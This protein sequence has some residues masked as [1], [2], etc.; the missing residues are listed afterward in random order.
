MIYVTHDQ[1][2]AMTMA[3]RIVVLNRG[4]IEQVGSPLDLYNKPDSLFVAGFIGSPK[5]N[6]FSGPAA[7][8]HNAETIGIRP[9]HLT[10]SKTSGTWPAKIRLAE[11]LG[12]DTFLHVD[13][14]QN[15]M[16]TVRTE[17]EYDA[18]PGAD[19]FLTPDASR[20]HRFD[21]SG[22]AMR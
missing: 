14:G 3:D 21:K 7:A 4:N 13:A 19:I 6:L 1:V 11:H 5:M 10:I 22:K 2:E 12:A 20:I 16:M 9:E 15:G 18:H 8:K 17:G